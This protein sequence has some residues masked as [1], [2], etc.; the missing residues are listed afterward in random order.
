M[1]SGRLR[2]AVT[3]TLMLAIGSISVAGE[4]PDS[5]VLEARTS[6]KLGNGSTFD[7]DLVVTDATGK[8]NLAR[9]THGADGTTI[10]AQSVVLGNDASVFD[11]VPACTTTSGPRLQRLC[12]TSPSKARW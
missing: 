6:I 3:M 11:V 2:T 12:T 8:A 9:G 4:A 5:C 10:T 1:T 7:G